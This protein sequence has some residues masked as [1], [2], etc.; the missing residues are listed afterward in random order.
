MSMNPDNTIEKNDQQ[1]SQQQELK[2]EFTDGYKDLLNAELQRR[3]L[4]LEL[5]LNEGEIT[6]KG[7]KKRRAMLL[8]G[9]GI[10]T[11]SVVQKPSL[12]SHSSIYSHTLVSESS[13]YHDSTISLTD[14]SSFPFDIS[15]RDLSNDHYYDSV[16]DRVNDNTIDESYYV[17]DPMV[18]NLPA[19]SGQMYPSPLT[20]DMRAHSTI[21][22]LKEELQ[23]PL[24]PRELSDVG[25]DPHNGNILMA[26]FDNLASILRHRGRNIPKLNAFVTLD[27]KGKEVSAITWDKLASRAEKVAQVIREKSGLYRGDRVALL[28]RDYEVIDFTVALLGCFLAG[29][30]AVPINAITKFKDITYILNYTQSHLALTTDA[31][32]KFF[33][34]E[35]TSQGQSWPKGVEWWKANEFGSYHPP[36]KSE[37]PALQVPDLAYIE[38]SRAPTGEYRGVV[39]SHKTVMHQMNCLATILSSKDKIQKSATVNS[40]TLSREGG[41]LIQHVT[42][43]QIVLTYLDPRQSIGMIMGVLM[44]IYSGNTTIWIPQAS[45]A[46][47]G[48]YAHVISRYRPSILLADYPGLKQVV[49]NYQTSPLATRNFSKRLPVDFSSIKWCLIDSLTVD[50]EF[51]VILADR[52]LKP[53]GNRAC[54]SAVAPMLTLSEHGGMVIA[55][56]DWLG[57]EQA[58]GCTLPS[59]DVE[60]HN[61]EDL[62][63]L[64]VD[65]KALST[66]NVRIVSSSTEN[67]DISNEARTIIRI[68]AFGYPLPDATLAIVDPETSTLTPEL[69][70]GEVWVDSPCLSG[71][72]WGLNKE[73]ELIFHARC[74]GKEGTLEMEFLRTG[75]LGFIYAGKV[76]ILG[77]YEDRLRQRKDI[78]EQ[79]NPSVTGSD[80]IYTNSQY[81]YHYTSHLVQTI[82]QCI[83]KV[84]DSS[85]FDI[86]VNDEHFPVLLLESPLAITT[87]ETPTGPPRVPDQTALDELARRCMA[88]LYEAHSVR[89]YCVSIT[90]P[91]TLPRTLRNGRSEIGTML[92]RKEFENGNLPVVYIKFGISN[93]VQKLG[94][95]DLLESGG[96]WSIASSNS[97][98]EMLVHEN[99]QFSGIDQRDIVLDDRTGTAL[100]NFSSIVDV[101]QWRVICQPEELSYCTI[102]ARSRENKGMSWKKFDVRIA[103]VA[104]MLQRKRGLQAG[105]NV[106]LMYTH[107]E[108][109]VHAVYA[110]LIIG[111]IPIAVTPLDVNRLSEDVPALLNIIEDYK[112]K[113]FLVNSE[114]DHVLKSKVV[115]QHLKQSA[116]VAQVTVP[117][118]YNTMKPGKGSSGCRELKLSMKPDWVKTDRVALVW[119]YWTSD[120]RR[121]AVSL[122]HET[123]LEMCKVQKETCQMTSS[124]PV[125]GCVRSSCGL[126][127]LHTCFMGVYTGASTYLI[128]PVDYASNPNLLFLSLSRYK[129][130]DTYATQQ[131][132]EHALSVP[133][134]RGYNLQETRSLMVAFDGRPDRK[135]FD[136]LRIHFANSGLDTTAFSSVY[137]HVVNPMIT[138]RSY[139]GIEPVELRLDIKE[140]RR[141]LIVIAPPDNKD[142][143][144]IVQ[145]SG[146]V[147]I[148]THVAIVNPETRRLCRLSEYG[149]IWVASKAN[150]SGFYGSKDPF[151]ADRFNAH[152]M[153]GDPSINFVRTGDLGFLKTVTRPIGP[154]GSMVEIQVLFVL[155]AV[156]DTFEVGGLNHFALDIENTIEESHRAITKGGCAVFQAG[157]LTIAVVEVTRKNYLASIVPVVVNAVLNEHQMILDVVTFVAAGDFPRSR[158]QE[159]QRG[160]ILAMWVT[161]KLNRIAQ[162]RVSDCKAKTESI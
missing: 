98:D 131:M 53:L 27:S 149:E 73:T 52:W 15:S 158:L 136:K 32:L 109:F 77:L 7:Y 123:I 42:K 128:S 135:L 70:V 99:K 24:E 46:T 95:S 82:M 160:K 10:S 12:T 81:R 122:S 84:F 61:P 125:I 78:L 48:L 41:R 101:L 21:E 118:F 40:R 155:G 140:L 159:K 134:S 13:P 141:G 63:E 142:Y 34:R 4:E 153:D 6:E 37:P 92:C 76:Y 66:N 138:T 83:P 36:K 74:W 44:T 111:V 132:L 56:R 148:N 94:D 57:N 107:S 11:E 17:V 112:I 151:D 100:S 75:L 91:N 121:I 5:E 79:Q 31:N 90:A 14:S 133:P 60:G 108:D 23:M 64:Y 8:A 127:F 146:M 50:T 65:K 67:M 59:D 150:A 29:V 58:L 124:K 97:R 139:M 129:I 156:G 87:P 105:D 45:M 137:S 154:G 43:H 47:P 39:M 25:Y 96:I 18:D 33:H 86:Y 115:A 28:Y 120:H 54:R 26:K 16:N 113:A 3:L 106:V 117:P 68:G 162:F 72:F 119:I 2:M 88:K 157:G 102:D 51:H 110:C 161:R 89:V 144:L 55:M 103:S 38:F 35:F 147:P 152:S 130:K 93:A 104:T 1:S 145:D 49:Y 116:H 22:F 85:A 9:N 20:Q 126:G 71:G 114:T 30:V 143:A 62:S 80:I 69:V 19:L